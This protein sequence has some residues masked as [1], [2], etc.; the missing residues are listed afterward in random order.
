MIRSGS[1]VQKIQLPPGL[2]LPIPAKPRP[3]L[4][5]KPNSAEMPRASPVASVAPMAPMTPMAPA[6]PVPPIAPDHVP[7][8]P[9]LMSPTAAQMDAMQNL[10]LSLC[11]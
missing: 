8:G 10:W 3:I 9:T 1:E 4:G 7:V 2:D 6:A 11:S 5:T